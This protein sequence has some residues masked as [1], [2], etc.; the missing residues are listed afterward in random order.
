VADAADAAGCARGSSRPWYARTRPRRS[1][2]NGR[3]LARQQGRS[4]DIAIGSYSEFYVG[5][6]HVGSDKDEINPLVMTLFRDAEKLIRR[7][8]FDSEEASRYVQGEDEPEAELAIVKYVAP[9]YVV[10][11]RLELM[12]FT[13]PT[14]LL[15]FEKAVCRERVEHRE[16][17][18][19]LR[20]HLGPDYEDAD[21]AVLNGLTAEEWMKGLR[22]IRDGGL[23]ATHRN[24][25]SLERLP[26]LT[27]YMLTHANRWLGFPSYEIRH[28]IRLALEVCAEDEVVYDLTDLAL[29]QVIDLPDDMVAHA[30][31]LLTED[32]A[33][34]RRLI[35][36]T[37]GSSDRWMIER[38]LALWFPHLAEFYRFMDFDGARVAGGAGPLA[39]M[40]KAF[41]GAGIANRV[42]ALF[43]ND[44]AGASAIRSLAQVALPP[45]IKVLQYPRLDL[46]S[47]YPTVGPSG[48]AT[49]DVNGLACSVELYLGRD[50]LEQ[51]GELV[52]VQ[53]RGYD[54]GL[55]RYQ[56]EIAG[57]KTLQERFG[58]KLSRAESNP[59]IKS[60]Q[61][62]GGMRLI[63]EQIRTAFHDDD[64]AELIASEED[65][66]G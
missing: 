12:G 33:R 50:V 60:E 62:W 35:I 1:L 28:A 18:E 65:Q 5:P 53:W 41:V 59:L 16:M 58:E 66:A 8:R 21:G 31:A 9:S 13:R 24:D 63:L 44:T 37:E 40:V 19:R 34:T 29:G 2:L 57:K 36:L 25:P 43:D 38:S 10:R 39:G 54:E 56:G 22:S 64:A 15:T 61:D 17:I 26:P 14:A 48:L 46:A 55:R 52:P 23:Q 45:N 32:V 51:D 47:C 6:I 11:D 27:R 7:V 3:S 30:D 20:E 49:M 4:E 42:L